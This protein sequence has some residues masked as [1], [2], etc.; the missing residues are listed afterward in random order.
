M[1]HI[2]LE[3]LARLVSLR[4]GPTQATYVGFGFVGCGD[5]RGSMDQAG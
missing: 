5:C 4:H 1:L 3:K 2:H